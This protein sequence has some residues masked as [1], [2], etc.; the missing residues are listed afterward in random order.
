M[1]ISKIYNYFNR[2]VLLKRLLWTIF[3][4]VLFKL[5]SF[6]PLPAIH[7]ASYDAIKTT[8]TFKLADMS[9]GGQLSTMSM[10]ILG[11]TPFITASLVTQLLSQHLSK[12]YTRW[13]QQ[14]SAGQQKIAQKTKLYTLLFAFLES[15]AIITL[16]IQLKIMKVEIDTSPLMIIESIILMMTGAMIVTQLG[17]SIN[18][19]GLG[20]GISVLIAAGIAMKL[21]ETTK[22][23]ISEAH[24]SWNRPYPYIILSIVILIVVLTIIANN[25]KMIVPLQSTQNT[26]K[27]K[28]HYLP[29]K[30][31]AGSMVPVIFASSLMSMISLAVKAFNP[32]VSFNYLSNIK[33]MCVYAGVIIVFTFFYNLSQLDP[34]KMSKN[35]IKSQVY[36]LDHD[37]Y[38]IESYLTKSI[39]KMSIS[40]S[41]LL[42]FLALSTSIALI[43]MQSQAL[44]MMSGT[45]ILILVSVIQEMINQSIGLYQRDKYLKTDSKMHSNS[46]DTITL[47]EVRS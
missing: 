22:T 20:S 32:K 3:I 35:F 5:G 30:A 14:G 7:Y 38:S 27:I 16:M 44:S 42:A 15:I 46:Q 11:T 17:E 24:H 29:I 4:V 21:P 25:I 13:S 36:A 1:T 28:A 43:F 39:L 26:E 34:Q 40:G 6:V 45:S 9:S 31:L 19:H 41:I 2:K 12:K 37:T 18:R 10:F 33:L 8:S 47:R 23:F